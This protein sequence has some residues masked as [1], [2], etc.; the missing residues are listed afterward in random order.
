VEESVWG[1]TPLLRTLSTFPVL[2]NSLKN[3]SLV[4][5]QWEI[6]SLVGNRK[7]IKALIQDI[8]GNIEMV[9]VKASEVKQDDAE[10]LQLIDD[11]NKRGAD[12]QD[13]LKKEEARLKER[14][15]KR[16]R[17]NEM[18][19]FISFENSQEQNGIPVKPA[20]YVTLISCPVRVNY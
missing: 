19:K 20:R 10:W 16:E 3:I 13:V 4:S 17:S 1:L 11:Q 7:A 5:F 6:F 15:R 8:S 9:D 18:I 2:K 14:Q 12:F